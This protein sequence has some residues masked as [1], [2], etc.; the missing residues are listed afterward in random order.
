MNPHLCSE[1]IQRQSLMD[2]NQ[3]TE[4]LNILYRL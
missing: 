3:L 1:P 2:E 4:I